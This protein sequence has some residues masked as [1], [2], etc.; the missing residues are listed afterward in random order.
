[1]VGVCGSPGEQQE[2]RGMGG[3]C[4]VGCVVSVY[5]SAHRGALAC[6]V[7]RGAVWRRSLPSSA[8]ACCSCGPQRQVV[9]FLIKSVRMA[10]V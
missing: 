5:V 10:L 8:A 6:S 9:L 2:G 1:M 4:A 3:D 7:V